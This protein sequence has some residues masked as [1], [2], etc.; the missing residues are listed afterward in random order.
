MLSRW[1]KELNDKDPSFLRGLCMGGGL[2]TAFSVSSAK[3]LN[4]LL[5]ELINNFDLISKVFSFNGNNLAVTLE[6][7]LFLTH[8]PI[9]GKPVL[10]KVLPDTKAYN[11][12]SDDT[13]EKILCEL[14]TSASDTSKD[15]EKRKV[16]VLM[17]LIGSFII[18]T[19]RVLERERI[20]EN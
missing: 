16:A 7:I 9:D 10:C 18:V 4:H 1:R 19:A 5:I 17:M 15:E 11:K 8:L 13:T 14:L 12:V 3:I 20:H 6:D 2:F